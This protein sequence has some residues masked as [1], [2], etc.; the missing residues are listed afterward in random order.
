MEK[1]NVT[2][3]VVLTAIAEYVANHGDFEVTVDDVVV[4]ADDVDAYVTTTIEKIDKKNAKA[5]EL[6]AQKKAEGDALRATI[7]GLLTDEPQTIADIMAQIDD[8]EITP[9]KV[10]SRLTQLCKAEAAFK[11]DVKVDKRTVKAYSNAPIVT[12][13]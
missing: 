12:E 1:T 13:E 10:V 7:A 11:T 5:A 8:P 9:A 2:K 4:T 3:R 6:N